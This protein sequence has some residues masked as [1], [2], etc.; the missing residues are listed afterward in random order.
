LCISGSCRITTREGAELVITAGQ[1]YEVPPGHDAEVLGDEPY[2]TIDLN[3]STA[4]AQSEGA[5]TTGLS[6]LC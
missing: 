1:F 2:A 5:A 3:P 4:F 6:R